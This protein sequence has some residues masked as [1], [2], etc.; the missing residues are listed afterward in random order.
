M[1]KRQLCST[2]LSEEQLQTVKKTSEQVAVLKSANM[3][4]GV[5]L[6]FKLLETITPVLAKEG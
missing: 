4:V 6:I 3:S 2:G 1:Y 5:N